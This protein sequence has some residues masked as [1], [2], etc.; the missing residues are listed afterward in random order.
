MRKK[1]RF[2]LFFDYIDGIALDYVIGRSGAL[3][4]EAA[5]EIAI[6]MLNALIYIHQRGI[7]H[8]DLKPENILVRKTLEKTKGASALIDFGMGVICSKITTSI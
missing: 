4:E 3:G 6:D 2:T 5:R 1:I 8:R 7:I